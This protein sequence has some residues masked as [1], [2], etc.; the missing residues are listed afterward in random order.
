MSAWG[1][2]RD[3]EE[4]SCL[5]LPGGSLRLKSNSLFL[6]NFVLIMKS[7]LETASLFHTSIPQDQRELF[8]TSTTR[9]Q[10]ASWAHWWWEAWCVYLCVW[11]T[12]CWAIF[13]EGALWKMRIRGHFKTTLIDLLQLYHAWLIEKNK[14][15]LW[16]HSKWILCDDTASWSVSEPWA[17]PKPD[18]LLGLQLNADISNH[19]DMYDQSHLH[20][21]LCLKS[22]R[23]LTPTSPPDTLFHL[24]SVSSRFTGCIFLIVTRFNDSM[25]D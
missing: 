24:L 3:D 18:R 5:M 19:S 2:C 6:P 1:A 16:M 13:A 21:A 12:V 20:F 25:N 9:R 14:S 8:S 11:L 22:P 4:L 7:R 15:T 17:V 10:A 23:R